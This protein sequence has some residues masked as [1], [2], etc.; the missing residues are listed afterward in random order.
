MLQPANQIAIGN[1]FGLARASESNKDDSLEFWHRVY[2]THAVTT[3]Q[4]SRKA[5]V[6]DISL[7]RCEEKERYPW[8]LWTLGLSI[9]R[10]T[11]GA[12]GKS[13]LYA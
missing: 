12:L 10:I 1:N 5:L 8:T 2:F 11:Y 9:V 13:L 3:S 7:F 4:V 6:Q